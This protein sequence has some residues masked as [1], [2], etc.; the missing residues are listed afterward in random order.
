MDLITRTEEMLLLA[1][2]RLQEEAF[3]LNIRQEVEAIMGKRY[4]VGGIYVPLDRLVRKGFLT[5]EDGLPTAERLGRPRRLYHI[6]ASGLTVLRE[7][8]RVHEAMWSSLPDLVLQR[9]RIA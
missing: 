4:S 8:R 9:L 1:V 2:C 5:T 6:T 3:G 7:A